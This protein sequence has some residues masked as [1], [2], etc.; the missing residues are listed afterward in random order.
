MSN[1][2]KVLAASSVAFLAPLAALAATDDKVGNFIDNLGGWVN[3]LLPI[4]VGLALLYFFYGIVLFLTSGGESD[5]KADAKDKI[6]WG[7]IAMF[8]MVS[9]WGL[10]AFIGGVFGVDTVQNQDIPTLGSSDDE[11]E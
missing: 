6:L 10:V 3:N 8:V 7:V 4:F 9:I 1:R 5:K 2:L 11:V